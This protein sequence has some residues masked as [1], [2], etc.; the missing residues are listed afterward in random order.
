MAGNKPGDFPETEKAAAE[1]LS[2]PMH[3]ELTEEQQRF[4]TDTIREF[5]AAG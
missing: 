3:T 1:V 5:Y 2:L 4:I